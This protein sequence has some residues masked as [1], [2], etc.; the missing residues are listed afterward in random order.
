MALQD[1]HRRRIVEILRLAAA[2]YQTQVSVLPSFVNVPDEIALAI[3]DS[4]LL[5]NQWLET[6]IIDEH[7]FAKLRAL[8]DILHNMG[9]HPELWTLD[10][11]RM[12]RE[13]ED[14]RSIA[15]ELLTL[16]GERWEQPTLDWMQYVPARKSG[17]RE[18]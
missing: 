11:L 3:Y 2:E 18:V 10:A 6:G 15:R 17:I 13:W 5:A 4:V 14:I 9:R 7:T 12:K 1:E 16:L 8:D